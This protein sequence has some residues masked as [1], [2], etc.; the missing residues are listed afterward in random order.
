MEESHTLDTISDVYIALGDNPKA[1][2]S[3]TRALSLARAAG[4]SALEADI[5]T[6]LGLAVSFR[7][8]KKALEYLESGLKMSR[9]AADRNLEAV[10]LSDIGS[11]YM[12]MGEPRKA[13]QST[14]AR[15][16]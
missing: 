15:Q 10:A 1:V 5:L 11:V 8:P 7:E 9:S 14:A 16:N 12:L 2:D 6:N 13:R 4:D 3:L